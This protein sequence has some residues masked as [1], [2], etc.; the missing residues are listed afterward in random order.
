MA[1]VFSY[2]SSEIDWCEDN[3]K[4]SEHVVEYFNTVGI[5]CLYSSSAV[6]TEFTLFEWQPKGGLTNLS[7]WLFYVLLQMSSFIFFII[8]PIM[9]Y[10]LHPYAKERNLAI[11]LV[12]IMMIFVGQSRSYLFILTVDVYITLSHYFRAFSFIACLDIEFL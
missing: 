7:C 12:W 11:H 5:M 10:L 2:E 4:H 6:V 1:G 8:S 9:L 3:Y